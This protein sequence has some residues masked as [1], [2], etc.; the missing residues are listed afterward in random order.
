ML[1]AVC[2]YQVFAWKFEDGLRLEIFEQCPSIPNLQLHTVIIKP[3]TGQYGLA[4]EMNSFSSLPSL[5]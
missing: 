5:S 4:E 3:S 1:S 2:F